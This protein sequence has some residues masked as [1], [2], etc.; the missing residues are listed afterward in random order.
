MIKAIN[1]LNNLANKIHDIYSLQILA[2]LVSN[3]LPWSDSA[4]RPSA[5]VAVLNEIQVNTR[6]DIVECGGGVSTLLIARLL[7]QLGRGHLYM[8]DHDDEWQKQLIAILENEKLVQYVTLIYAPLAETNLAMNNCQ[9][10]DTIKIKEILGS[11]KIDLL[12]VDGP[13]AYKLE[14][15][16][17]RYPAVPY[18]K[19]ILADDYS[20]VL[21][22]INRYGE[23]KILKLWE[24]DLGITFERMYRKGNIA[25]GRSKGALNIN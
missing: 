9:W 19:N 21:D 25:L 6:R 1:Y 15:Q 18:F 8:I 4:M 3:Y 16:Y 24:E 11:K 12:I 23:K 14:F 20:I 10:Y 22:D 17:A 2:P 7:K 13:P 5:L